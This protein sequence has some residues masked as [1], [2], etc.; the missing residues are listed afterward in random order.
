MARSSAQTMSPTRLH[1][2][3]HWVGGLV[4]LIF[5]GFLANP[6]LSDSTKG[7]CLICIL[8]PMV[9]SF[10]MAREDFGEIS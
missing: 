7:D 10:I 5:P 2:Q 1:T 8:T 3:R 9:K 6:I 4:E